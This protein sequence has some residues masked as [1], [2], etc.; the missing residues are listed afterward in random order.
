M[1][2][3]EQAFDILTLADRIH[4]PNT[5]IA[6]SSWGHDSQVSTEIAYQW[7]KRRGRAMQFIVMTLDTGIAADGYIEW[8]QS[9]DRYPRIEVWDNPEVGFEWYAKNAM[10]FGFGHT[11]AHHTNFYYRMLKE[12]TIRQII[13]H[14]KH[15]RD[16]RVMLV[17]GVFRQESPD[18]TDT[19][20]IQRFGASVWVAPIV[21]WSKSQIA[22]YR[23]ANGLPDNPFYETVGGSGDCLCNWGLFN[24]LSE[25]EHSSPCLA[26]KIAAIN[27]EIKARH[28]W[29]W[30]EA[31]S[32]ALKQENAGQLT[33][34]GIE[35]LTTP[36]LCAGCKRQKP[37]HQ[38]AL[39][40]V[41]MTKIEW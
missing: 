31:P 7:A 15:S 18:R 39:D 28:G 1:K 32:N 24:S 29:G 3:I 2:H 6:L 16:D 21:H 37:G 14:Y 19:P 9:Q 34:P 36:F 35:P 17:S 26:R 25:I 22:T 30:G 27:D 13:A 33:L 5:I 38:L 41:A 10:E 20:E 8:V 23:I 4:R 40:N 12:R 11:K